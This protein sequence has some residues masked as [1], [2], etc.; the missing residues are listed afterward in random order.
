MK[1][2]KNIQ[3]INVSKS[4]NIGFRKND[5][6]LA[7]LVSF[8]SGRESRK[9]LKVL[10]NISFSAYPGQVIGLI[11]KNGSGKSTLLRVI[12]GIYKLDSGQLKTSGKVDY[13]SGFS[14]G[15]SPKLTMEENI[16]HMGAM[17]GLSQKD[18][19]KRFKEIVEFSGLE[20]FVY[21]K[22]YQFSSGMVT[23]LAFSVTIH[24]LNHSNPDILL[25]DEV[26]GAGGDIDF[27]AKAIEKMAEFIGSGATVVLASHN[28]KIIG[29]YCD[30]VLWI[31]NGKVVA[32]GNPGEICEKY[33]KNKA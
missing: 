7:K 15:L 20:D 21:T 4:F 10:K 6:A 19:K 26:F 11:G 30:E 13:L 9:E 33:V 31:D 2:E 27:E 28:L 12:A 14:N 32:N 16:H 8:I 1:K 24:C 5:G 18:I 17:M 29:Q 23:R 22:V 25:L 3:L